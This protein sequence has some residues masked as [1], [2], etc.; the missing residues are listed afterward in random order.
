MKVQAL[1]A[2]KSLS[3][4]RTKLIFFCTDNEYKIEKANAHRGP[5]K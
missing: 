1:L 5:R 2:I 4:T 3:V